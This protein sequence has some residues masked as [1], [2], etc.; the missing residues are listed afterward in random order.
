V[1]IRLNHPDVVLHKPRQSDESVINSNGFD[2]AHTQ[3]QT[4]DM[5]IIH[6]KEDRRTIQSTFPFRNYGYVL[7]PISMRN[8]SDS[9]AKNARASTHFD[10][11]LYLLVGWKFGKLLNKTKMCANI[12]QFDRAE[13]NPFDDSDIFNYF[14]HR[15]VKAKPVLAD[16]VIGHG[17][18]V[19]IFS[20]ISISDHEG[21]IDVHIASVDQCIDQVPNMV[22]VKNNVILYTPDQIA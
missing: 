5:D 18:F 16:Y 12:I 21:H 20:R 19:K 8:I 13:S 7:Y 15:L 22:R 14:I 6:D 2:N 11:Q 17:V 1:T 9:R 3:S 4:E 10:D